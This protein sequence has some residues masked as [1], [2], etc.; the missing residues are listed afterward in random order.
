MSFK[1]V[2]LFAGIGG[3]HAALGALGGECVYASEW[4]E[5]AA[6]IYERNWNWK[7][8]GDITLAANDVDMK[9]PP[10]DVLVG[11][12]P[13]QPFSKSGKQLGMEETRGTL[14]WNIAKIIKTHKPSIVLLENVRNIAGPR[15]IHEWQVIIQTLR[16]LGYRVS[17]NPHVVSPHLIK[18]EF[19][20]RPQVRERVFIAATLIPKGIPN[21]KSN[22][23][24]PD[25]SPVMDGWDPQDWNLEKHL[26]SDRFFRLL[27]T[28]LSALQAYAINNHFYLVADIVHLLQTHQESHHIS[29]AWQV[30]LHH[31]DKLVA[32]L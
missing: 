1:F 6:R 28:D 2:D 23:D 12:F 4:D 22:V 10:H 25:L 5:D 27:K 30:E 11:G 13:C 17:E 15:H 9:V 18:R 31:E 8:E 16:D 7:P 29:Q 20:G 19:G 24:V 14:F 26:A 21:F 3:F 32:E